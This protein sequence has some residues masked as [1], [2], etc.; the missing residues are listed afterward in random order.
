MDTSVRRRKAWR[1]S[2][3]SPRVV[4]RSGEFRGNFRP[5]SKGLAS[6]AKTFVYCRGAWQVS[7]KPP[8]VVGKL[9]E[10]RGNLR[11][12]SRGLA[13]F[14][15]TSVRR[16]KAWRVSWRL[17]CIVGKVY[18]DKHISISSISQR[19]CSNVILMRQP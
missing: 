14:V 1:V 8:S 19:H 2:R 15:A 17:S 3:K 10:F 5:S 11:A 9:G 12:L 18:I 4:E 7:W 13:S 6:F 16:Q